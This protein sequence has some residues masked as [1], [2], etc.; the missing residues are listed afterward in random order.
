MPIDNLTV[1]D[2]KIGGISCP[3]TTLA[4]GQ[5][6]TC[7]A[8]YVVTPADGAAGHIANT[9][10]ATGTTPGGPVTSPPSSEDIPVVTPPGIE[11]VKQVDAP[12]PFDAGD[13]VSYTYIV[14]NTG[15][16][17]I[18]DV[19]VQ[20][21]RITNITCDA[22]T[23]APR[24]S[25]GDVT[26]C[27]GTYVVT[28]EDADAGQVTNHATAF[29]TAAGA[30]IN[31]VETQATIDVIGPSSI[32]L[33]KEADTAGPV[34]VGDT[35]H[36]TYTVTNTGRTVVDNVSVS[37]DHAADVTCDTT[38]LN[39]G[40]S[41]LCHAA[42]L[43]TEA[44][45]ALGSL[46]NRAQAVGSDPL[47]EQVVSPPEEV[48]LP[49]VGVAALGIEKTA[50]SAGPFRLGDTVKY[51]YTVTNT[52]TATV[53]N[54]GVVDDRIAPVTCDVTTLNPGAS[55]LCHGSY[56]ITA[57]DVAAGHVTNT[58]HAEG[59]DPEGRTVQSPPGEATVPVV[60]I[61]VLA[62]EKTADSAGPFHVG[63]TVNYTYTVTNTGTAAVHALAVTDDHVASVTCDTTTLNPGASTLCH[64]SYVISAAD[65]AAGHVTNTAHA[66]GVD[67][68]GGTVQSPP[69]EATVPVVGE[70]E[71]GIQ[72]TADSAG[73]FHVGDTVDYTYTVTNTGTAAV[74]SLSVTDD[75]VA[76]VTCDA[77]TLNPG[78]STLCHG[79]Y[80]VTAADVTAG[81]VTNTAHANGTD[82]QGQPVQSPPGEATV[83]V[84]G[85][86]EL[87]IEKAADSAGPFHVGDAVAYTYTVTNTGTAAVHNLSVADD[88][89]AAVTCDATTLNPGASTLCHGTYV[90]TAADVTAGHVTNTAHANGA[91]PEGQ[92]VQSPPGEV[93]VPVVGEGELSI[94][95]TADSAG[96]FHV[97]DTVNYTYT[98][99]NTGTAAVHALTVTD[100]H[101][102]AVTCDAT[103]LNPGA[104]TLCHG[105]YVVTATDVTAGHVTNTAHA[106]GTD[107][108]GQPV[109]SPPGEATVPV[110]GEAVLAIEKVA[111][112]AGPFHV[113]DTVSYT[114]TVTNPGTAAVH[115]LSVVD[116]HVAVVTCDATT[117]NPGAST[118]CH[119]SYV[120][121]A[122]DVSAGHVTN[123]AHAEGTDPQGRT[124][125]SP[126]GE[127]TVPVLGEALLTIQKAADSAGPFHVG[128]TVTY[129]YTVTNTG[130]AAVH[131][132]A[133]SDDRIASVTCDV[134]TLN[135][136]ASTFCHGSYVITAADVSAG[137][138]TNTARAH[139][140]D[141]E[142]RDVQSPPGEA[143]I[144]IAGDAVLTIEKVADSAGPFHVGDTVNYTYTVT[145]AGTAPVHDLEVSDNL[146]G[147]VTCNRTTLPAGEST[148]CH[149]SYVVTAA[150]VQN[151]HV[152]N[153]AHAS[154]L[155]PEGRPVESPPGE[156]TV[157]VV[158][159][160]ELAIEKVADSAGPFHV[161]DTVSYTYTVTN[162]GTAAVHNLT[163]ADDHV[164][165][166]TCDAT[167]LNPGASTLCHGSYVV[168]AADVSA[169]H[170]TNTAHAE[171][172]D[173]EGQTVLSPPADATVPVAGE[174][175]LTIEKT[176]D[177]A[178]P[179]HVGETV[180]YTYTVTNTGTAAVHGLTV[181]DD[182][183]AGVTCN[184]TTL[185]PG[186]STLCHGSYVV[187]AADVTAGHVTNTAHANGTDPEGQEVQS[188][189]GE[190]TVPVA[191]IAELTIEKA[192]DAAGPFHV[193]D[194]VSYTYTVT[195]TGTAAVHSLTVTDDHVASVTCDATTLNPGQSTLCH[196]S[197]VVTAGDVSAGHVT[198]KAHAEGTDPEGQTVLS[199]PGEATV[200]VVGEGEL[201]IEK[202]ADSAGPFHVGETV[203]YTYTVTNTGTAAVH[204]LT[205][206]D[207]HVASVTCDAT[208]LN[209]GASTLCHGSYVVTAADVQAGH[210]TNTAHANGTD[211][212]GQPVQ[213]PPGEV[214][215]PVVG[216]GQLT[217]E[218]TADS[219]GP[220]HVGDT[221]NYTYTVTNTGTGA[222]SSITVADDHIASVTCDATTLNPGASTLCHGSYVITAADVTAGHV[223]NTAHAKGTG[224]DGEPVQSPP[225]EATVPVVGEA[226]L[227]IEKTA[228]SAGPFHVGDTVTY[229]YTV[230]NTGTAALHNL[231]V[232][233]DRVASVTCDATTLNPGA[234]TLCHGTYVVTAGDV[235]A[236]HVTNTAHAKGV[237]PEGHEVQSP[238][239]EATVPVVGEGEL[240][241]EKT[242]D[243]TGP[244][245]VGDTVNYTYTVTNTGTA[246]VHN[247]T[248]ADDHVASVTCDTTTLNPGQSALCHGSYVISAADVQAGHVTNTA[249]ATGTDPEG[250]TVQSPPG[251]ATVPVVGEALLSIEKTAD[252]AGPFHVGDTVNY[253]YTVT[254][255]GTA[256]V[257]NVSVVDDH[258]ESV[259]CNATTLNPSQSTLCHGSYVVTAADVQAG[260]VTNTAHATGTDPEGQ[261][262]QSPPIDATVP[263]V[264]EAELA[265]EK[266]ADS[267]GPFHVGDTVHYTYTVTNTGTAV[268]HNVAVVDD[269]VT[270]VTCDATT[271]NP[272]A[273]TLCQGSYTIT[274]ADAAA[275][276]V[277]NTA[278]ANG[279]D[280]N[281]RAVQSPPAEA[282]VTVVGEAQ[283]SIVKKADSAGPFRVGDTVDYT[284]TVTNTG[285]A[286]VHSLSVTDDRVASVTCD[287]TT[288]N[289]GASTVCHGSY[290]ITEE[291]VE[292][293]HVTNTARAGGVDPEGRPVE[294]GPGEVTVET[295]SGA[296]SLSI[297]K[298]SD[299]SGSAQVGDTVTYTYT[300]TNTGTTVLTDV[301]VRDDRVAHVTCDATTLEPGASTTCRGVYVVTEEDAKAGHVINTATASGRDPQGQSVESRPVSLCVTVSECPEREKGEGCVKVPRPTAPPKHGGGGGGHLPDTG[302][303]AG[304]AAVGLA[305]GGLLTLGGVLLYRARRRA[306][307]DR[308]VG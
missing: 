271:L 66:E 196:G 192:A 118:L 81:H 188:P 126:P 156:T 206:T 18:T 221:V 297:V 209:P 207:D 70:A 288:L 11:V 103:T 121:T 122:A 62:I 179:F 108:E 107:P 306:N 286:A 76:A 238:P 25:P 262:V 55:T 88:H 3:V 300:V 73:P 39:P 110:V 96:P 138:V 269:R 36:Y 94:E 308:F 27:H 52:G 299:V 216:E 252:S 78:A 113:G 74:H 41:T 139:G 213:S 248:V 159:E 250:R 84:A 7:T 170:V 49:V 82:P 193:G 168:T 301:M 285:T 44:D 23:L 60:G 89:V 131:D 79:S 190:A 1:N 195:N 119:G 77:T 132:L 279:T 130:T 142:G 106:N 35:V 114:Y 174:G 67:P 152:T 261:E 175:R 217:I 161:G 9:A 212:E 230:T 293:G 100:D 10:Q 249:R 146:I 29:G 158:G 180:T 201:S 242:A 160:A 232:S 80:V 226:L 187:T 71:L 30:P 163:V 182:H 63:E 225:G 12:G 38:T 154:G 292:A 68:E 186:Q 287:A 137:Q 294:S 284:Y 224:P 197:Y 215:V 13:T 203:A 124:V 211:P 61:A 98:V 162:T 143:T 140:T 173:P 28:P 258:V 291:D 255:T 75:H 227:S 153:T 58:A 117:L 272:G 48:T 19:H 239:I 267:A 184:A 281:G 127:A 112:S 149:G 90:V 302:S 241:I 134:T 102:A 37:D 256:V 64:G 253:T 115:N 266:T 222:V 280:P 204:G 247:V 236:G 178:G 283:L 235:S 26:K 260:H 150:D 169:G 45:L 17:E 92:P 43:V 202:A 305:G 270:S 251:E 40:Q 14:S 6:V 141:P 85:I 277:T 273:S 54:L 2:P 264:G 69:G 128:E 72:K 148:L 24:G 198:N 254:N 16:T 155:D 233:D 129:T 97:G 234:S 4:V 34:H 194:T 218:K 303:P 176:A 147:S 304:L 183:V 46:T 135:P 214:T 191:G 104:S 276:H 59:V 172:T 21:D 50:D 42:Y 5:T 111:D 274:A 105:T 171:G 265:V 51:T 8:T 185:N 263:V 205:V 220:F 20:D 57:A 56:V 136:G 268:I 219:A 133:V 245:H 200:P 181:T 22:T 91:D 189:P 145:N 31:S 120:V 166:V 278:R 210:V 15:G 101:V 296:S 228:D 223:T 307:A 199:P 125:V 290:T 282:T 99:T 177:S 32:A 123:T 243:A 167:T 208:T 244:F 47:G 246:A 86:A 87:T 295:T 275:G 93:T 65:V 257:H 237:D 259:T 151:G 33:A 229:T 95:K 240:A 231:T 165:V 157:P 144:D 53:H 83:P 289:P 116:D 298:Q 164:A 109:V